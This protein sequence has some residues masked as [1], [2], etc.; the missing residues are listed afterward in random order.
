MNIGPGL[1]RLRRWGATM[2][3]KFDSAQY[4]FYQSLYAAQQGHL[5]KLIERA[6]VTLIP[7]NFQLQQMDKMDSCKN[8]LQSIVDTT[9]DRRML[10]DGY[11]ALGRLLPG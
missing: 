8:I 10:E 3:H 7:V 9:H 2:K 1:Q 5:T 4:Y 6:C 11:Y